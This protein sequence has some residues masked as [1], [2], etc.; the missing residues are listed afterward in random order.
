MKTII[1]ILLATMLCSAI[2]HPPIKLCVGKKYKICGPKE[3]S[4][5]EK[6]ARATVIITAMKQGY[7]QYCW[8][9]EY[10]SRHR[11]LF[12]RSEKEFIEQ[13]KLCN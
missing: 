1:Y 11:T 4:P 6:Q 12:S 3:D 9:Y 13:L 8:D 7:V 10:N 5:F 2:E